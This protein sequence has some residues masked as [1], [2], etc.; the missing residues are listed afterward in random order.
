MAERSLF[1]KSRVWRFVRA[2]TLSGRSVRPFPEA[3]STVREVRP[4]SSGAKVLMRLSAT[5]RVERAWR[6]A[7]EGGMW[8]SAF[9]LTSRYCRRAKEQMTSGRGPDRALRCSVRC[10]SILSPASSAGREWILLLESSR[11]VR[12]GSMAMVGGTEVRRWPLT[13]S[14]VIW[15]SSNTE[16]GQSRKAWMCGRFDKS[17]VPLNFCTL[18]S[19]SRIT[20]AC[21][22]AA[23]SFLLR[24]YLRI[25][26]V[27]RLRTSRRMALIGLPST[28]S[29]VRVGMS[30]SVMGRFERSLFETSSRVRCTSPTT[31][32]MARSLLLLSSRT[33]SS[34]APCERVSGRAT[35]RLKDRYSSLRD[36]RP[37]G[38]GKWV[39]RF[40]RASRRVRLGWLKVG[41]EVRWLH[42]RFKSVREVRR[43]AAPSG[44]AVRELWLTSRAVR[45]LHPAREGG[46]S[47]SLL[48]ETLSD[49]R[50][51][52]FPI[53]G[54]RAVSAFSESPISRSWRAYPMSSGSSARRFFPTCSRSRLGRWKTPAGREARQFSMAVIT[55]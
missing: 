8:S 20:S 26:T 45:A 52:R 18:A 24:R 37:V 36:L 41:R 39:R 2:V 4:K 15:S 16:G 5:D 30:H 38:S 3:R 34:G 53:F 32:S 47:V 6:E 13:L 1:D 42:E 23:S 35:K 55:C 21:D 29:A 7:M 40:C 44:K 12:L 50:D 22:G 43:A 14:A 49:V 27:P 46:R 28:S 33:E 17:K 54:G 9:I 51:E 11:C 31:G 10:V 48:R 19:F 25:P